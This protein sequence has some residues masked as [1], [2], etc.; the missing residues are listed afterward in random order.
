MVWEI[1]KKYHLPH[2]VLKMYNYHDW[3]LFYLRPRHCWLVAYNYRYNRIKT[4]SP[5]MGFIHRAIS[6]PGIRNVFI[7]CK[8]VMTVLDHHDLG[9]VSLFC[10]RTKCLT[11]VME[12]VHAF[13]EVF[14]STNR[15]HWWEV[16]VVI[17]DPSRVTDGCGRVTD[18]CC[19]F[20]PLTLS[21][22]VFRRPTDVDGQT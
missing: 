2:K 1:R 3:K 5:L 16:L 10:N 18:P 9:N 15:S 19:N 17:S 14:I 21:M 12:V 8:T 22:S 4:M 13:V 11:F 6:R 20:S 7:F